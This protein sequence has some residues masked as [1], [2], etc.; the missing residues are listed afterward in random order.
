MWTVPGAHGRYVQ[1]HI[2]KGSKGG[3]RTQSQNPKQ[4]R[5]RRHKSNKNRQL[6][7]R[8]SGARPCHQSAGGRKGGAWVGGGWQVGGG[9]A[10]ACCFGPQHSSS[11]GGR[12]VGRAALPRTGPYCSPRPSL[13]SPTLIAARKVGGHAA[14]PGEGMQRQQGRRQRRQGQRQRQRGHAA[15][16]QVRL[17]RCNPTNKRQPG[18]TRMRV[19]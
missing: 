18:R 17:A 10:W 3:G 9:A 14:A 2:G 5:I 11:R 4:G 6:T 1:V 19:L 12:R 16:A 7:C 8:P 13:L 15:P